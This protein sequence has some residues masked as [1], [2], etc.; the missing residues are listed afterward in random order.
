MKERLTIE[1]FEALL[2]AKHKEVYRK[3]WS[4]YPNSIFYYDTPNFDAVTDNIGIYTNET[5]YSLE[6]A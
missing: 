4:N 3:F 1:Q 2:Q 6:S 5:T